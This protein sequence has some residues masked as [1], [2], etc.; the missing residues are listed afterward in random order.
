MLDVHRIS[1]ADN[2]FALRL[3]VQPCTLGTL[4]AQLASLCWHT[5]AAPIQEDVMAS[6][7]GRRLGSLIPVGPNRWQFRIFLRRD[8]SGKRI[9]HAEVVP[10]TKSQAEE[11]LRKRYVELRGG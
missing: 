6:T 3:P 8:P 11:A 9:Y 2:A 4:E 10:G 7:P 1:A 5:S